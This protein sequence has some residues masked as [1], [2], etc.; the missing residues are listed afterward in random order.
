MQVRVT[1]DFGNE[2]TFR[3]VVGL[4]R[5]NGDLLVHIDSGTDVTGCERVIDGRV[6]RVR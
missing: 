1:N 6:E 5:K 2:Q 3:N 4:D